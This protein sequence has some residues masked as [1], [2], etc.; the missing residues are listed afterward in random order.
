MA[1]KKKAPAKISAPT[2]KAKAVKATKMVAAQV[3]NPNTLAV[4]T[5]KGTRG[6]SIGSS[7]SAKSKGS[8]QNSAAS[9]GSSNA[10]RNSAVSNP[11]A[12]G[13]GESD[14]RPTQAATQLA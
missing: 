14:N 3:Q 4:P 10:S 6:S 2:M 1:L 11:S 13:T 9:R 8:G 7:N 12:G 5:A